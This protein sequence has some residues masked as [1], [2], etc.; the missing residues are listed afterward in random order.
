M[1]RIS[2]FVILPMDKM[3]YMTHIRTRKY[4]VFKLQKYIDIACMPPWDALSQTLLKHTSERYVE[5]NTG[6]K[7]SVL[8]KTKIPFADEHP[9][10]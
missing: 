1:R 10:F 5:K 2:V 4:R 7:F 3:L 8:H 9:L 6:K